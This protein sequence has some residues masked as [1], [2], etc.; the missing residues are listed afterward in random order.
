MNCNGAE[1]PDANILVF[2]DKSAKNEQTSFHKYGQAC[3]GAHCIQHQ[4]FMRGMHY[5]ILPTLT[6]DG[7]IAYD[8]IEGSVTGK[9]FIQFLKDHVMLFTTP[10]P[11]HHTILVMDNCSIHHGE[12][13][14]KL[15]EDMHCKS[16]SFS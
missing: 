5:S 6:L 16:L 11:G 4:C 1:A 10:Y 8:I 14:H 9:H 15:V 12:E 2:I 7:I 13:V 3:K